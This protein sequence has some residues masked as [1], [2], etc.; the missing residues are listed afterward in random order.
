MYFSVLPQELFQVIVGYL[1]LPGLLAL[2][3]ATNG[4]P[5]AD[6]PAWNWWIKKNNAPGVTT[7]TK[8]VFCRLVQQSCREKT[9]SLQSVSP[10]LKT[11]VLPRSHDGFVMSQH[12]VLKMSVILQQLKD[13]PPDKVKK[14]VFRVEEMSPEMRILFARNM[15]LLKTLSEV[16]ICMPSRTTGNFLTDTDSLLTQMATAWTGSIR[17]AEI[18]EGSELS[19]DPGVDLVIV[20]L[21]EVGDQLRQPL[22]FS[23]E[24]HGV[25]AAVRD[26]LLPIKKSLEKLRTY[27]RVN[28]LRIVSSD[29][30]MDR[31]F[32]IAKVL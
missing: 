11:V 12:R 23:P 29:K 20:C 28:K 31:P 9:F 24:Y 27:K 30:E 22:Q 13:L 1:D 21:P 16:E 18:A 7:C 10:N 25:L 5:L 32:E 2:R 17:Y 3:K 14:V 19:E 6:S 8:V 15:I 26:P 4:S